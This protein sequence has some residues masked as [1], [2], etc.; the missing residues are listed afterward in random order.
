MPLPP[1][2]V[3]PLETGCELRSPAHP[4]PCEYVRIVDP[5]VGEVAYWDHEEWARDPQ[6]VMGAIIGAMNSKDED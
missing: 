2:C 4:H 3:I 6:G 1:E 5:V